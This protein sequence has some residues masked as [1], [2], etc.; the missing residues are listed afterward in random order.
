MSVTDSR[1]YTISYQYDQAGNRTRMTLQPG[2]ADE[3]VINY[4]YDDDGRPA[5]ITSPAGTFIFGYDAAGRRA[6][7]AYPNGISASY[8]YDDAGRLTGLSYGAAGSFTYTY[9]NG[10]DY[11]VRVVAQL[12]DDA[13]QSCELKAHGSYVIS[14]KSLLKSWTADAF[15]DSR[16]EQVLNMTCDLLPGNHTFSIYFD[17]SKDTDGTIKRIWNALIK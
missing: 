12:Y 9:D 10:T 15:I 16:W 13:D 1:G 11:R 4:T 14:S 17:E 6:S 5:T 2:A 3:R 7:L 8:G